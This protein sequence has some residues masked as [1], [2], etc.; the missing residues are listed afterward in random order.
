MWL[1]VSSLSPH[2]LYL[3]FCC[4]WSIFA[5]L[6]LCLL[7]STSRMV[8]SI[9]RGGHP[10]YLSHWQSSCYRDF[11][12]SNFLA[13][14]RYSYLIFPWFPVVWCC[15]LPISPSISRIPFLWP[16]WRLFNLVFRLLPLCVVC[17]FSL[18]TWFVFLGQIP[19]QHFASIFSQFVLGFPILQK[20]L[21][22]SCTSSDWSFPVIYWVCIP[23]CIS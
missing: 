14:L 15:Q 13:L 7:W 21:C 23:P 6:L 19:F 18:L 12:L 8:P 3:L 2:N 1:I 9:L 20:V 11:V 5:Y 22:R 4:V 17:H 10:R 16:F